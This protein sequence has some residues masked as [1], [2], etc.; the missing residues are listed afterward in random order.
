M[1]KCG[2]IMQNLLSVSNLNFR[3]LDNTVFDGLTFNIQRNTYNA[4]LGGNNC[5]KTTLIRII[6]GILQSNN[7]V[8]VDGIFLNKYNLKKYSLLIGSFFIN[9]DINFLFED[10]LSEL[11][12][13]VENLCYSRKNI[14]KRLDFM[15]SIFKIESILDKKINQI[16]QFEKIKVGIVS[17]LMHNPK[18]LLLD[19]V[20]DQLD[21]S[22]YLEITKMLKQYM[23]SSE[24]TILYTT[25]C[26]DNCLEADNVLLINEKKISLEGNVEMFL[27]KDN[28][29][30]RLGIKISTMLDMSLKLRFYELTDKIIK[31]PKEMVDELWKR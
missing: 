6:T 24:L 22:Q 12:F 27:S 25:T 14:K 21:Y 28:M 13:S 4:L 20:F 5:G 11:V 31:N 8:S 26:L 3:Y 23:K 9:D 15:T 1:R 2:G 7:N 10:V 16:S 19:D 17:S 18:L 30:S 29:L